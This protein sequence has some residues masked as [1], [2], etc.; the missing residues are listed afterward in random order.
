SDDQRERLEQE[1]LAALRAHPLR[2][3][4]T[5]LEAYGVRRQVLDT[6]DEKLAGLLD[7]KQKE[8]WA[9]IDVLWGAIQQGNHRSMRL[10]L[11]NTEYARGR[12]VHELKTHYGLTPEQTERLGPV[13]DAYLTEA[14]E[15]LAKHGQMGD[16]RTALDDAGRKGLKAG[17][18]ALQRRME[19]ELLPSLTPEQRK[20][21]QRRDPFLLTFE[22]SNSTNINTDNDRG[23]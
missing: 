6:I 13:A 22:D 17:F 12:V 3:D 5:A 1:A 20:R 14:K 18:Y 8:T 9:G 11:R 21:L 7:G 16:T 2:A 23:F 10:G 4:A 19:K 15:L